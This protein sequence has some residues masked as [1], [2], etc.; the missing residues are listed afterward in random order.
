MVIAVSSRTATANYP[1][2]ENR[3]SIGTAVVG[4]GYASLGPAV[5]PISVSC[6]SEVRD[7]TLRELGASG[8]REEHDPVLRTGWSRGGHRLA[9]PNDQF[10]QFIVGI[11]KGEPSQLNGPVYGHEKVPVLVM[12]GPR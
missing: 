9:E 3:D 6:Q 2:H 7:L 5:I 12:R 11:H 8:E 4:L 10:V 1:G